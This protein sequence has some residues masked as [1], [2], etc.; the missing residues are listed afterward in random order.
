[1]DS[2]ARTV[3]STTNMLFRS[4][5]L[6]VGVTDIGTCW[7]GQ[8]TSSRFRLR[9][10]RRTQL[11][12][13]RRRPRRRGQLQFIGKFGGIGG[14]H[15]GPIQ[16][17]DPASIMP[18][19]RRID[20]L[21]LM[22]VLAEV[23]D[24]VRS[25]AR[26]GWATGDFLPYLFGGL[27]VGRMDVTRTVNECRDRTIFDAAAG[28]TTSAAAVCAT[29][30]TQERNLIVVGWTAGLGV[31]YMLWSSVVHARRM[32]IHQVRC[33]SSNTSITASTPCAPVSATSSDRRRSRRGLDRTS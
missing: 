5:T 12:M 29:S 17:L 33:R 20:S 14:Q 10:L 9:R 7:A 25:A 8:R 21:T 31:E 18:P 15:P 4:T 13:G 6:Q 1:M 28:S 24:E 22:A 3:V 32:G 11:A 19:A 27:A 30:T 26:A 23:K 2:S 16:Y